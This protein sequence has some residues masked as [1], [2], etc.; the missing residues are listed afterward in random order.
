[1]KIY[2][3]KIHNFR[4]IKDG[5]FYLN[6]Y[7]LLIGENNAGKSNVFR[8][9]RVFYEHLKFD[10]KSDFPKFQTS[11]NESWIEIEFLTSQEEQETL[12][13]EY[14]SSDLLLKVRKILKSEQ[15]EFKTL[16]KSNQSNIFAYENGKLS[17]NYFYGAKNISQSKLGN[18]IYIPE[19]SK[20]DDS[21][22]MTGPSPLREM[23]NFVIK[24]AVQKSPS[25]NKLNNAFEDFNKEF[26]SETKDDFSIEELEND[27]NLEIS[28][29][30]IKFGLNINS[31]QPNDIV[32]NLVSHYIQDG[33][34]N[35]QTVKIDSFGQ[36]VQ[37]HLIYTLLKLSSK[38]SDSSIA[39][40]KKEFNP[41]LTLIL[42]EE[43]EAFLHPSQQ[44]K[45]NINLRELS[46][47]NAQQ[48]LITTHSS[49]F[50]SKNIENLN[51]LIKVNRTETTELYQINE[52]QITELTNE[53]IGLFIHFKNILNNNKT[54]TQLKSKI[55][56][57]N[58]AHETNNEIE[59][60]EK[61]KFKFSL[62]MDSER[63]S[64]FFAKKVLICEGASEKIFFDYLINNQWLDLKDEHL[65]ILDS[66]GKY[67][68]H[69]Y[70]NLFSNL[71]IKHSILID[72]D[73]SEIHSIINKFIESKHNS[74]TLKTDYFNKDLEDFLEIEKPKSK[75]LKPLNIM[76]KLDN[77]EITQEKID[78][79]K[80]KIIEL[81]N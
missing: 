80:L 67:N 57:G 9:L 35:N 32:K 19:V 78:E 72:S 76:Q 26:R 73:D 60:T 36:G 10:N 29:W 23:I 52:N 51:S 17:T 18:I 77:G 69:R 30:N 14:K 3:I 5:T 62:W 61:E 68:V 46:K 50:V 4:S 48:I 37:R 81:I 39:K 70:M 42:F 15:T 44:E 54:S 13:E 16:I 27:V 12:K 59:Q 7:S 1:M 65:Y 49:L 22:K 47:E 58:L 56:K 34:L 20:V 25:F 40:N 45:L 74:F 21:L 53:N 6:D 43:P 75:H 55:R 63:T 38:Y 24:K 28:N 31:I 33:N 71:G 79:L 41:D 8:A 64:L 66:L 2:K 11:D